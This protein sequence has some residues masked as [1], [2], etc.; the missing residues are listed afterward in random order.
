LA[1]K[2]THDEIRKCCNSPAETAIYNNIH[3]IVNRWDIEGNY[4][5]ERKAIFTSLLS[6]AAEYEKLLVEI[7]KH[8]F[9]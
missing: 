7:C 8:P 6:S 9:A 4:N 2:H 3:K 1:Y 5:N